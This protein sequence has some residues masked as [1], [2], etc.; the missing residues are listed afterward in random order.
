MA[1]SMEGATGTQAEE[2]EGE[3]GTGSNTKTAEGAETGQKISVD[4]P[5][6]SGST[7][8]IKESSGSETTGSESSSEDEYVPVYSSKKITPKLKSDSSSTQ[9]TIKSKL[10]K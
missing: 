3:T 6:G 5:T 9:P 4:A 7:S 2:E 8:S 10:R 1:K